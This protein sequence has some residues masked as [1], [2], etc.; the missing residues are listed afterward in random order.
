MTRAEDAADS[1]LRGVRVFLEEDRAEDIELIHCWVQV[2]DS[3]FILY[4]YRRGPSDVF[5]WQEHF[6]ASDGVE[7]ALLSGMDAAQELSEPIGGASITAD[8]NRIKWVGKAMHTSPPKLPVEAAI[9]LRSAIE[10]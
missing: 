1:F 6:S 3:A 9:L 8:D 7:A 2:P 5:G 10:R 4:R